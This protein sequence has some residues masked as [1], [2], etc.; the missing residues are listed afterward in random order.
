MSITEILNEIEKLPLNEQKEV[1]VSLTSKIVVG[2][3]AGAKRWVGKR[4]SFDEA[5][6]VVFRENRQLLSVLDK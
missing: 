3:T 2:E 1:F 6:N 4:L 5:C